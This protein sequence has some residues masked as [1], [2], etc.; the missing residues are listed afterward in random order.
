MP[1]LERTPRNVETPMATA[2]STQNTAMARPS[3][4]PNSGWS[5]SMSQRHPK[6]TSQATPQVSMMI[7]TK[8]P[9]CPCTLRC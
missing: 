1:R 2:I 4:M 9:I 8:P 6:P 3:G 5:P 7:G